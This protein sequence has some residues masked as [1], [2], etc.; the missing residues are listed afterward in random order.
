MFA[1][2]E[3]NVILLGPP[4]AGKGTQ[5][6]RLVAEY[7]LVHLSTGDILRDAVANGTALG[8][9]AKAY[10]DAGDLVP[11]ELVIGVI[12]ERLA[13]DDIREQGV[14]LDGFPRTIAQAEALGEVMADL[15]LGELVVVNIEVSDEVLIRRLSGRRMCD[16]CE[17]IFHLDRDGVDVGDKCPKCASGKIYQRSD[18]QSE[19]IAERLRTYHEKTAPLID[20]YKHRGLLLEV[21]GSGTPED[22][23]RVVLARLS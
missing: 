20:Y 18:D 6:S 23:H 11:D 21:D 3:R 7:G 10:M 17:A 13:R 9:Q 12:R 22:V 8:R 15:E 19:A 5:A 14:L 16:S 4:G 1:I 2:A